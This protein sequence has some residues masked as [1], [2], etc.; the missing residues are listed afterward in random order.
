M[1]PG[2]PLGAAVTSS[3]LS[4]DPLPVLR[5]LR[6]AEPVSWLPV[7]DG[8]LVTRYDLAQRVL[9]DA[10]TFTVDD[11]RF[12]TAQ[13][14]GPSMLSLDGAA[15][16]RHR[17]PFSQA[18]REPAVASRL[19][20]LVAE[21]AARLTAGL[22]P[23]GSAELRRGLA[24]P[25]AAAV[26]A[27]VLGL[28]D[29]SPAMILGWYD[30][31]VAAVSA[32]S[33]Q[34]QPG[35]AQPG[36]VQPGPAGDGHA[37]DGEARGDGN[38][39]L[40]AAAFAQL[41]E[42]IIAVAG[43]GGQEALLTVAAA[44]GGLSPAEI[45][46]NAAVLMFGGIETAEAMICNAAWHLLTHPGQ[47]AAVAADKALVVA[48][49]EESLRLEPAAALLD[50]Y[51]T[52]GAVIGPAR[53]RRG[54][55]VTVSLTAANTD[56]AVF[57]D[58]EA[59]DPGRFDGQ[60]AVRAHLTFAAGPHF[61]IGA[62]LARLEAQTSVRA[63]LAALPGLRLDPGYPARPQGLVFRKPPELRVRWDLPGPGA[64]PPAP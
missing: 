57:A 48:A 3:G 46:S 54:D 7:L 32:L 40:G 43:R 64:G 59:F 18:F 11:P 36:P 55:R 12:S 30:A 17:D 23:A 34:A 53:I 61:C 13:V 19:A 56:P 6:A 63:L 31:I 50:R 26:M 35:Y 28:A 58:P 1:R 21:H 2:F 5:A 52:A 33:G 22:A 38:G 15:H 42:R 44:R 47:L 49:V 20:A 8:W 14:V 51:A 27:D 10:G 62:Q 39:S 24:G 60:R 45:A 41:R 37:G 25:L 16:R 9:R 4:T 29:T